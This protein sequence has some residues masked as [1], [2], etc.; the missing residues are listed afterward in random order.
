MSTTTPT[1]YKMDASS[2]CRSI[3]LLIRQHNLDINLVDVNLLEGEQHSDAY[4]AINPNQKVPCLTDGDIT[5][6][7]SST[8]LRY[9][10]EKYD[11]PEYP[12]T[13]NDRIRVDNMM[14]FITTDFNVCFGILYAYVGAF[15]QMSFSAEAIHV[16]LMDKFQPYRDRQLN[17]LENTLA[18]QPWL[19]GQHRSIADYQAAFAL[20]AGILKQFSFAPFPHLQRWL[21]QF[22]AMTHWDS[23]NAPWVGLV[24]KLTGTTAVSA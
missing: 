23:V 6:W 11:L 16:E 13:T 21:R 3:L 22:E 14:D 20:S 19:C 10:C 12:K 9:L 7:Q 1:L 4:K 8:I 2:W 15:P 24:E 5:L 18:T 17:L